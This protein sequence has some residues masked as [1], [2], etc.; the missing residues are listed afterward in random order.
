MKVGDTVRRLVIPG[1][2]PFAGEEPTGIVVGII[3]KKCWRTNMLGVGAN[4]DTIA[5]EP[6]G[7]I[8]FEG[9]LITIPETDIEVIS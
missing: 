7:V 4:W 8:M 1:A 9:R 2:T 6:H 3:Q 5:P